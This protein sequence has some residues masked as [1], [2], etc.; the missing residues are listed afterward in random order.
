[1]HQYYVPVRTIIELLIIEALIY[2]ILMM[3]SKKGHLRSLA[4][5]VEYLDPLD[6]TIA[7]ESSSNKSESTLRAISEKKFG[8][9][10]IPTVLASKKP[11][12][13]SVGISMNV[14]KSRRKSI[15]R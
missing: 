7:K 8:N 3:I 12:A 10:I 9:E 13:P 4:K 11:G 6:L 2:V 5:N 14:A 15:S 1:M